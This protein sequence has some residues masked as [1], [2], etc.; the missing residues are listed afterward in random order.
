LQYVIL[1]GSRSNDPDGTVVSYEWEVLERPPGTIVRLGPTQEDAGNTNPARREFRLFTAG[2]YKIG[3][4]VIDN[5]GFRACEQ[6]VAT[7]T[8]IPNQKV[9]IELTWTNPEDPNE[10]D[11]VGSDLDLHMVKMGPG[12]W[13]EA[14]YDIYFANSNRSGEPIWNPED[15]SLDI[16]VTT[17]AGPENVTMDTL[18]DCEWYAIGVHYFRE[19]FGT[20][21]ATVRIYIN[22][23]LVFERLNMPMRRGGQFWDVARIHWQNGQATVFDVD[24]LAPA[25]P[26]QQSPEVT[27]D[28]RDS[29]LCTAA[30]L[31]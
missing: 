23:N 24:V 21:F 4:T 15:P 26:A 27:A 25:A 28:M 18:A 16:D 9:H 3:L 8:A 6:A 7:I 1:D 20:A 10:A 17:G 29:G 2:Q 5:E 30:A 31:Y 11:D 12:R 19:M 22:S 13:F 14:P